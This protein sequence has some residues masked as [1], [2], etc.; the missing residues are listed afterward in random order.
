MLNKKLRPQAVS[1]RID[2]LFADLGQEA[3]AFSEIENGE[4][5]GTHSWF[6]KT[7]SGGLEVGV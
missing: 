7:S 5:A 4:G 2:R 6:G 3:A 1:N